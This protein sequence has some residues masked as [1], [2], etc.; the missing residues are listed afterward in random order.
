MEAAFERKKEKYCELAAAC[1]LAGWKACTYTVEVRCRGFVGKSYQLLKTPGVPGSKQKK[2]LW[3]VAEEA[4]K[5][6]FWLWLRRRDSKWGNQGS[7]GIAGSC[8]ETSLPPT[9]H[10]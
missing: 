6:S 7:S 2:V 10:L 9:H 3:E 4:E 5:R 1:T 8:R